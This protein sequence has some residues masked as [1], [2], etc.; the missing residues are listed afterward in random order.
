MSYWAAF[1]YTG[2]PG[3]GRDGQLPEWMAWDDTSP[4][5]PK[6]LVFDTAAGGGLRLSADALT[7]A[8]VLAAVDDD[9]RL[10][11]QRDKCLIFRELAT[12]S[13]GFTE[14][15]YPTAGREGC[16]PYPFYAYPWQD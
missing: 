3:R 10:P 15:D 7:Q 6:F 12:W 1:A 2:A 14:E 16:A 11:T 4:A 9:P 5:S 8:S 13:T